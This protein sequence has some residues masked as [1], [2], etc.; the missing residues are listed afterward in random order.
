MSKSKFEWKDFLN[1]KPETP[2][3]IFPVFSSGDQTTNPATT[4]IKSAVTPFP[5]ST[6]V[7]TTTS[8]LTTNALISNSRIFQKKISIKNLTSFPV[9]KKSAVVHTATQLSFPFLESLN[10]FQRNSTSILLHTSILNL[11]NHTQWKV[12]TER[13]G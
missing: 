6:S 9:T 8:T 7:I 5:T 13:F 11:Y 4:A 3:I 12:G 2:W 1:N 10:L